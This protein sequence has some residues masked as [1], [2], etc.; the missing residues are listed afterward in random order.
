MN[1]FHLIERGKSLGL[2]L[3]RLHYVNHQFMRTELKY[4]LRT[5]RDEVVATI[6]VYDF[7]YRDKEEQEKYKSLC[8]NLA[9]NLNDYESWR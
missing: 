6:T 8:E 2:L 9:K 4:R 3:E 1:H 5:V 7:D